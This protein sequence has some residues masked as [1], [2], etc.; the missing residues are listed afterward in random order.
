V[1]TTFFD[2][3]K[4]LR[5]GWHCASGTI[6]VRGKKVVNSRTEAIVGPSR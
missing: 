3:T 2:M 1:L 6:A 5:V 4:N